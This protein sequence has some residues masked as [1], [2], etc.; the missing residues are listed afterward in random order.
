M[1]NITRRIETQVLE[2]L[3]EKMVLIAGP[4]QCGKTTLAESIIKNLKGSYYNWDI[5]EHQK[6]IKKAELDLRSPLWTL[7]EIHKYKFWRNL[8][9]GLYDE[10]HKK[11]KILVT[12][13]AKLDVYS[14]GGDSLQGRYFFHRLHPFTLSE[15]LGINFINNIE[16]VPEL[17]HN[18]NKVDCHCVLND[19]LHYSGFPE[20]FTRGSVDA[21]KRWSLGYGT[22]LIKEEIRDLEKV[23]ELDK[24]EL[25]YD[26]LPHTVGSVLSMNSLRE[27]LEIN[28]RTV[29]NWINIF[30]K[31]YG[32]FRV[33][34]FGSAKIKAVK[35]EQKL[36]LWDWAQIQKKSARFENLIAVHLLR[37]VHYIMDVQ[38]IKADLRFFRDTR[39]REVDFLIIK[40]RKPWIAIEVK[41]SQSDLDPN[42]KYL[43]EKI[44]MPY[45]FQVHLNVKTFKK[46]PSING[47]QIYIMPAS[48]F[49]LNL[50]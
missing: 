1:Q 12:G 35:K 33:P 32:C 10:H 37:F 8:L 14:R 29:A 20:P 46:I 5:L 9:K 50:P 31:N 7:D 47:A 38:G 34:P 4:R 11:H 43:L 3:Q 42:L 44:K 36:Y 16:L 24:M 18:S 40:D 6:L 2:D 22:R 28:Y 23:F 15:V 17:I 27:D 48:E 21:Y 30:E 25:L 13:S 39:K 49:L 26:H 45:A 19:L 41:E